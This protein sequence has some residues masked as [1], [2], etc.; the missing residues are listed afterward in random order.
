[1]EFNDKCKVNGCSNEA[2]KLGINDV[3]SIIE[4]CDNCWDKVYRS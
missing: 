1:M 2:A 4:M 3:G